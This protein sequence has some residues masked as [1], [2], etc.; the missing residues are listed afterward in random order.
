MLASPPT[1]QAALHQDIESDNTHATQQSEEERA[2]EEPIRDNFTSQASTSNTTEV[3]NAT[4]TDG[5]QT[6]NEDICNPNVHHETDATGMAPSV[7]APGNRSQSLTSSESDTASAIHS[8]SSGDVAHPLTPDVPQDV[9]VHAASVAEVRNTAIG[10][11]GSA[12]VTHLANTAEGSVSASAQSHNAPFPVT[13]QRRTAQQYVMVTDDDESWEIEMQRIRRYRERF[14]AV[15]S[16]DVS[17]R[18][19]SVDNEVPG[20]GNTHIVNDDHF[21]NP[22]LLRNGMFGHVLICSSYMD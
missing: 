21:E 19:M 9:D 16:P 2:S 13:S 17:V 12:G 4:H 1:G 15:A 22:I 10:N 7:E 3:T 8:Q 20:E 6:S 11:S 18:R 14:S 5:T